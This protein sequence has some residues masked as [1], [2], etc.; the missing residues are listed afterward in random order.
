MNLRT[1]FIVAAV[2]LG[3]AAGPAAIHA[4]LPAMPR[5]DGAIPWFALS[6]TFVACAIGLPFVLISL[7]SSGNYKATVQAW[8]VFGLLGLV[9]V[10]TGVSDAL[11]P[12]GSSAAES[13]AFVLVA[14]G[15][16]LLSGLGLVKLSIHRN[17]AASGV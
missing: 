15:L 12:P 7:A 14:I 2:L 10:S 4:L 6:I 8:S 13:H 3:L 17:R 9:C 1:V 11:R 5:G 16:G